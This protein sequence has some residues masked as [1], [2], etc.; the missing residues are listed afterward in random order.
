VGERHLPNGLRQPGV[1]E[2]GSGIFRV[3]DLHR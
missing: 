3:E 1:G 2:T